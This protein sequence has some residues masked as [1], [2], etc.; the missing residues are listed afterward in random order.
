MTT[1]D[2]PMPSPDNSGD[3]Q[4]A[5]E[6]TACACQ[7]QTAIRRL[8]HLTLDAPS[9]TPAEIDVV[10]GY[11]AETVAALPQVAAHLG[12]ILARTKDTH[13]LAMMA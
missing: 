6:L 11:L 3:H 7:A 13:L 12:D 9:L 5:D 4:P 8:A 1:N 10:L 2:H